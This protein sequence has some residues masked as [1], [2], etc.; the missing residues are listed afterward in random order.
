MNS[1]RH[2]FHLDILPVK[3]TEHKFNPFTQD[4]NNFVSLKVNVLWSL[5]TL[6]KYAVFGMMPYL[7]WVDSGKKFWS[8][9]ESCVVLFFLCDRG[10]LSVWLSVCIEQRMPYITWHHI[11]RTQYRWHILPELLINGSHSNRTV[12]SYQSIIDLLVVLWSEHSTSSW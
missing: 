2:K 8:W 1:K 12:K 4:S 11:T 10:I 5:K 7:E 3:I 9:Q 6:P